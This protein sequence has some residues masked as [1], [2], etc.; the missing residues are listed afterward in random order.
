M[1]RNY[2]GYKVIQVR[3]SA[4]LGRYDTKF[5][6]LKHHRS[7]CSAGNPTF[8]VHTRKD[9][10]VSI[11][12]PCFEATDWVQKRCDPEGVWSPKIYFPQLD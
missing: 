6:A 8:V 1:R 9:K 2:H 4:A 5:E 7:C 11:I 12:T 10:P 3:Q